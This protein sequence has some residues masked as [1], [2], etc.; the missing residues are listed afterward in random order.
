MA[1]QRH[2]TGGV[3]GLKVFRM[4]AL[5]SGIPE[6]PLQVPNSIRPRT[7]GRTVWIILTTD[8]F[9]ESSFPALG[10]NWPLI[11]RVMGR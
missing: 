7:S 9:A 2:M 10:R 8:S 11:R 3:G 5:D 4:G 1:E 6:A